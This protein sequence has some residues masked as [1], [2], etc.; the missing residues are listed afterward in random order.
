VDARTEK[1]IPYQTYRSFAERM[2]KNWMDSPGHRDNLLNPQFDRIGIG[3]VSGVF[4]KFHALYI[5]QNFIGPIQPRSS[6]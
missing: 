4:R 6:D 2:V 3:I 1:P 5:T